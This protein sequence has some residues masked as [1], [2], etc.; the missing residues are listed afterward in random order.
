MKQN[1][2]SMF[3]PFNAQAGCVINLLQYMG[4][5]HKENP[6]KYVT[7]TDM[8]RSLNMSLS[9]TEKMVALMKAKKWIKS[10]KGPG[11]GYVL[12][13]ALD[14]IKVYDILF[15]TSTREIKDNAFIALAKRIA[16][17]QF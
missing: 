8:A 2:V 11:G 5:R 16:V 7:A 4:E 3:H 1:K 13:A 17:S 6:D 15:S 10:L 14:E 12:H 9:Y